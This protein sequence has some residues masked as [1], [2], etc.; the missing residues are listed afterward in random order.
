MLRVYNIIIILQR[1]N[2]K[3][4]KKVPMILGK[5]MKKLRTLLQQL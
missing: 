2:E 3:N 5:K 1:K 4:E